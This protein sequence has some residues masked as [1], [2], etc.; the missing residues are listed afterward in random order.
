MKLNSK[1]VKAKFGQ[2]NSTHTGAVSYHL[3]QDISN[4]MMIGTVKSWNMGQV[5]YNNSWDFCRLDSESMEKIPILNEFLKSFKKAAK[6]DMKCPFTKGMYNIEPRLIIKPH[7]KNTNLLSIPLFYLPDDEFILSKVA[8][9]EINGQWEPLIMALEMW[10]YSMT[11]VLT[12]MKQDDSKPLIS[13]SVGKS[14]ARPPP[15]AIQE[16]LNRANTTLAELSKLV[17]RK[18]YMTNGKFN[19]TALEIEVKKLAE[20]KKEFLNNFN[21]NQTT[22]DN[23]MQ[24]IAKRFQL[25]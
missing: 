10:K 2:G 4:L 16:I 11:A 8:Q 5:Y 18:S 21:I 3:F 15:P 25:Q 23:A 12:D 9:T 24:N 6:F 19:T 13:G 17:D 22:V 20:K 14:A 7:S 1:F